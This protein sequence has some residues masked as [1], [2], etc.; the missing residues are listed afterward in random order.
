MV[1]GWQQQRSTPLPLPAIPAPHEA[2]PENRQRPPPS[3]FL[4]VIEPGVSFLKELPPK[5]TP[6]QRP[7]PMAPKKRV[8][9]RKTS[10]D[11]GSDSGSSSDGGAAAAAAAAAAKGPRKA[12]RARGAATEP[13]SAAAAPAAG[14]GGAAKPAPARR[15][16]KL[17][18][19]PAGYHSVR[20]VCARDRVR[21]RIAYLRHSAAPLFLAGESVVVRVQRRRSA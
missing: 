8:A 1:P 20:A 11:D 3:Q 21:V 6:T 5:C 15:A 19:P 9:K 4:K 18:T 7:N 10:D 17:K 14:A 2:S 12:P 16:K 13:D